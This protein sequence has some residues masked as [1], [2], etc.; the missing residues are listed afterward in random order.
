MNQ[1][2]NLKVLHL[3]MLLPH[4]TI[5]TVPSAY[6]PIKQ[7]QMMRFSGEDWELFGPVMRG[8]IGAS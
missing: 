3:G 5:N 1:A 2:A 7:M 6:A 8:D 4:I